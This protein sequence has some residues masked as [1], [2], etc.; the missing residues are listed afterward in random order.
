MASNNEVDL[1]DLALLTIAT[2]EASPAPRGTPT[3]STANAV[4]RNSMAH[5]SGVG[6]GAPVRNYLNN[7]V[8]GYIKRAMLAVW[9]AK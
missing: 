8:A 3:P 2:M 7:S 5:P 4:N 1:R 6:A 9:D